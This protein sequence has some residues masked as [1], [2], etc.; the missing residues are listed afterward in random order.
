MLGLEAMERI[1]K[2]S[3]SFMLGVCACGCSVTI[4]VR[5]REGLI[6]RFGYQHN[7]KF[8]HKYGQESSRWKNG[9]TRMKKGYVIDSKKNY[10]HRLVWEEH[11]KASLLKWADVHHI[12]G[13]RDDN[14]WYNLQAM[15]K[16]KHSR[17]YSGMKKNMKDRFCFVL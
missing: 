15:I 9:T 4:P 3:K 2:E 5:T 11:N 8:L 17:D 13:K 10:I 12:N 1:L 6:R 7:M 16:S 14:V